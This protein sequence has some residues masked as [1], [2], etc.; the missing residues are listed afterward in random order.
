MGIG[1][2][3]PHGLSRND[4]I[5]EYAIPT[6]LIIHLFA[7]LGILDENGIPVEDMGIVAYDAGNVLPLRT[8]AAGVID[9]RPASAA[10]NAATTPSSARTAAISAALAAR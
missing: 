7:L 1:G 5:R 2:I 3:P 8:R 6:E 4:G 9:I 10:P